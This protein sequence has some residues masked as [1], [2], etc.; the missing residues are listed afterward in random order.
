MQE[1]RAQAER[2]GAEIIQGDV[3]SVDLSKRPFVVTSRRP[4][5]LRTR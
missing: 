1:L 3:T 5:M 2:F 4:A